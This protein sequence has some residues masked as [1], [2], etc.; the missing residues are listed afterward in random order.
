VN[1][2]YLLEGHR[3][4]KDDSAADINITYVDTSRSNM[5]DDISPNFVYLV[6]GLDGSGKIRRENHA[7]IAKRTRDIIQKHPALDLNIVI[8][9]A[10]GGS[11][12]VLGPS[13]VSE[14]LEKQAPTVVLMIGSADT[15]LDADNTLKTLKSYE[16]IAKLREAPVVL[17]YQHNSRENK[18]ETNDLTMR[19]VVVSLALLFSRNNR[20]LDSKDLFNFLRFDRVTS[21]GPRVAHLSVTGPQEE[22]SDDVGEVISVATLA[23]TGQDTAL[24]PIPEVQYVGYVRDTAP[25]PI[26]DNLPT[27]FFVTDGV[28]DTAGS[29]LNKTLKQIEAQQQARVQKEGLLSDGDQPTAAGLVI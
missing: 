15:R 16:A 20:E 22:L 14:L 24:D 19:G 28:Y 10:A 2:G 27:H 9:S 17:A 1:I 11:G 6:D 12:S 5:R 4:A 13:I 7:E 18:R 8:H 29:M 25:Q 21:F 3:E 26:L 23:K